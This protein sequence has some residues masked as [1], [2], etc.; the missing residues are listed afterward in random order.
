MVLCSAFSFT[1]IAESSPKYET[2][3]GNCA[4]LIVLFHC[5]QLGCVRTIYDLRL[6]NERTVKYKKM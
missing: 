6:C 1:V 5:K 3:Y 2:S 4:L